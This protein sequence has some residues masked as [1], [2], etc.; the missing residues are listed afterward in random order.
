MRT[1]AALVVAAFLL[2]VASAR[3]GPC[4]DAIAQF[5]QAVRQSATSSTAGP[6]ADQTVGAQT[7]RQP[8][9][10]S[11]KRAEET[12][13]ATFEAALAR[14]KSLDEQGNQTGCSGALADAQRMY[15]FR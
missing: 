10:E 4:S 12:A 2:D 15:S 13:Q 1:S 6:T 11:V 3:A 7:G 5:E 8:T 9:P 14:A